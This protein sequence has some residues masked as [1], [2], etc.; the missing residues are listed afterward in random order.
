MRIPLVIAFVL[1]AAGLAHGQARPASVS[2][3]RGLP[4]ASA[5]SGITPS[6]QHRIS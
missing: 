3:L 4:T 1:V 6:R 2:T 5:M